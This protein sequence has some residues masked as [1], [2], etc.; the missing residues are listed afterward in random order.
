MVM[1]MMID[2]KQLYS[3]GRF[4][5]MV[6]VADGIKLLSPQC[7]GS[8][9]KKLKN[10]DKGIHGPLLLNQVNIDYKVFHDP[11]LNLSKSRISKF[12]K[13]PKF[14]FLNPKWGSPKNSLVHPELWVWHFER[15]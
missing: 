15:F 13:F 3:K 12:Q 11:R 1:M 4:F 2:A 14:F 8:Y 6:C 5:M 9:I 7:Q 10:G